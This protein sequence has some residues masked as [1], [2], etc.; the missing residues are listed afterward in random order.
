MDYN[1]SWKGIRCWWMPFQ[2]KAEVQQI[3]VK[4]THKNRINTLGKSG[5]REKFNFLPGQMQ[6]EFSVCL[7]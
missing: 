2:E 3:L 4:M 5:F 1:F 7:L 6:P